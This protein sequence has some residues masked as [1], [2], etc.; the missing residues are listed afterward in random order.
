MPTL[1][2]EFKIWDTIPSSSIPLKMG[3][4]EL[5]KEIKNNV[6]YLN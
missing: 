3:W 4:K 5:Q 6:D 2:T 1:P